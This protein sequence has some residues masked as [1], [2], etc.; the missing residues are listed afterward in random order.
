MEKREVLEGFLTRLGLYDEDVNAA[1]S[2]LDRICKSEEAE[3]IFDGYYEEFRDRHTLDFEALDKDLDR[4]AELS[5]VHRFEVNFALLPLIGAHSYYYYEKLGFSEEFWL[6]CLE[7]F[8]WKIKEGKAVEGMYGISSSLWYKAFFFA[9]KLTFHRLQFVPIP[10]P[11]DYK[12]DKFDIKKGDTV[13]SIH[14]PSDYVIKFD[15]ENLEISY[16]LARNYYKNLFPDGRVVF[17]CR[18]WL[19]FSEHDRILPPESNIRK[20]GESFERLPNEYSTRDLWRIFY[21]RE[22]YDDPSLYPSDTSLQRRYREFL[23][24]GGTPG[25]C[26][27]FKY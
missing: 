16:E 13:I 5:G 26:W 18:S 22:I 2:H 25:A 14:I 20:F 12:S 3:A 17:S 6:H 7:D 4:V 21:T 8:R 19:M 23:M 24:S 27:G 10:C 15:E 9:T 11:F 1:L